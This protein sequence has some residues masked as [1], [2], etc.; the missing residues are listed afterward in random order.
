MTIVTIEEFSDAKPQILFAIRVCY[1]C[2]YEG[3]STSLLASKVLTLK[4]IRKP[5]KNPDLTGILFGYDLRCST[6][7]GLLVYFPY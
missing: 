7:G 4:D 5:A 2:V 6:F 1:C 3:S